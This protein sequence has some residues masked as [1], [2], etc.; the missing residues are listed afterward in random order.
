[1]TEFETACEAYRE[2]KTRAFSVVK[3]PGDDSSDNGLLF[4]ARYILLKHLRGDLITPDDYEWFLDLAARYSIAPGL[5]ERYPGRKAFESHDDVSGMAMASFILGIKTFP[6]AILAYGEDHNYDW[7]TEDPG[8]FSFR[9][10]LARVAGFVP[11]LRACA[12]Q[13]LT[14]L[15][16]VEFFVGCILSIFSD[17]GDTSGR[18]LMVDKAETLRGRYPIPAIAITFFDAHLKKRYGGLKGL[19]EIY[20][21]KDHPFAVYAPELPRD[22]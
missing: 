14:I 18:L 1:M 4:S 8:R 13:A 22:V 19:S 3:N 2:P 6:N 21:G 16:Q 15:D 10:Y 7:N 5:F 11:H 9:G 17:P 20:Y 12:G